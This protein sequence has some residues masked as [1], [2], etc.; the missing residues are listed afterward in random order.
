MLAEKI[1]WVLMGLFVLGLVV[2]MSVLVWG[3][4]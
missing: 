2:F 4:G 3:L 1:A